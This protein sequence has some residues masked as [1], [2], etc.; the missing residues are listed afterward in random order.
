[1]VAKNYHKKKHQRGIAVSLLF[2]LLC[3]CTG[4]TFLE[5]NLGFLDPVVRRADPYISKIV[6]NDVDFRA[7]ANAIIKRCPSTD[8][9]CKINAIYRHV[10]ENYTYISDPIDEELIQTPQQ[11]MKIKGGDCEDLTIL[12]NSLLENIGIKTYLI[13]TQDH[14]YSLAY[15]VNISNLWKYVEN[16]LIKQVEKDSG[17]NIWQNIEKTFVLTKRHS[18]Y[19]G[20]DGSLFEDSASFDYLNISYHIESTIPV[21]FYVV[22]S[23]EEY[24]LFADDKPFSHY[25]SYHEQNT[26]TIRGICPYLKTHGGVIVGNHRWKS[27]TITAN[28]TFY[29]HP[30]FYKLFKN[31]TI[32]SYKINTRDCVVLEATAGDYGYPGYD[33]DLTGEKIAIDPITK[34]YVYLE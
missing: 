26:M 25:S 8:K 17:E 23:S 33:A 15:D 4:C 18:W 7:Y 29:F 21:D 30:S 10:V 3:M 19:Y 34:E 9:E 14:T 20:G 16:S 1:V 2:L 28:I 27:T 32:K 24:T 13:L 5:E 12:L 11:T 6:V 22:S 31:N